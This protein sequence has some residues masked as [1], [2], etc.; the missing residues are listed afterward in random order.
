MKKIG[1]F[2]VGAL[3]ALSLMGCPSP[4]SQKYPSYSLPIKQ[5][6]TSTTSTAAIKVTATATS[7]AYTKYT[8]T[9][10]N[11]AAD[12]GKKF[13]LAG[14]SIGSTTSNI[15]ANWHVLAADVTDTGLVGTV[16]ANGTFAITFYG[17]AP[18]WGAAANGAQFKICR[19]DDSSWS[20]LLLS[21]TGDNFSVAG[22]TG[23]DIV[24]TIDSSKL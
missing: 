3:V 21:S 14:E 11:L 8:V 23:K 5:D 22:A 18:S 1:L 13:V 19:Y 7:N 16:D 2:V 15:G 24:L 9:V 17:Q 10:T 4:H 6:V 20:G 12:I